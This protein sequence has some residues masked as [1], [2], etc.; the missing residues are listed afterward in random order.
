MK[1]AIKGDAQREKERERQRM[2]KI[3]YIRWKGLFRYQVFLYRAF[4]IEQSSL[5]EMKGI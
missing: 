1:G 4:I 3:Y 5:D 2:R